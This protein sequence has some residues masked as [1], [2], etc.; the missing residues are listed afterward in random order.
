MMLSWRQR[1]LNTQPNGDGVSGDEKSEACLTGKAFPIVEA[2][3]MI[4][5][6]STGP[7]T[8]QID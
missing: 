4:I 2:G 5:F 8:K 3:R 1:S 7:A 6:G